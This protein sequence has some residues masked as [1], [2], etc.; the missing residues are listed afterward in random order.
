MEKRLFAKRRQKPRLVIAIAQ[1][2]ARKDFGLI[3]QGARHK[4]S[5]WQLLNDGLA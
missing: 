5:N 4:P 1:R 3:A 2:I